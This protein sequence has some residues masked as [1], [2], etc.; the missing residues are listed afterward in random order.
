MNP[1]LINV[2]SRLKGIK[3]CGNGWKAHCPAHDD[4][5]QSLHVSK[6]EDGRVLL[7]CHAGCSVDEVC[8]AIGLTVRDLYP[9]PERKRKQAGPGEV[10]ATYD[11]KDVNGKQLFQVCRTANKHFFQRRPNGKGGWINGLG[12]VK[13][14]LYRLPELLQ[15]V[16]RGETVFIPE[17][18]K[19]VD[20]LAR[21]GL[22]ATTNP[23]GAGKWRPEYSDWLKG[24]KVIIIPDND[25]PGRKHA[26]QVAQSLYGKV[27]SVK[28]LELPGLPAKGDVSDWLAAG[29]TKEELLKLA[30]EAPEWEPQQAED[31][32]SE[33][34]KRESQA[35]ALIRIATTEAFL[36]HDDTKDGYAALPINGHRETW[37]LR[38]KF[39]R[40]WLVRRYYEQTEK[41]PNNEAIRQAL[42]VV[43]ARAVFDGPEIKLSLRVAEYED[44]LWYDLADE[45]W[46]AVKITPDGWDVVDNPPILF[47]R[48][49]NTAAQVLPQ[50]GGSLELLRK[51]INLQ[52]D[53][54]WTLLIA[55]IVQMFIPNIPHAIPVFYGDKG[56]AKTTAQRVIRK[57]IDPAHRDT[58]TLPSDKN[59]LA[60]MLMTNYAP[61]FDNL[62]GLSTWQ[63]DMLCQ[64]A[65]GGGIS[66]REL[67]TDTEEVIL[68]FLRCPMLNGINLV[69]SR[70]DLL[71]RSVLF[72]LERIDENERKTENEFWQEFERDRPYILGAIFDVLAK[73]LQIYPNVKLPALP[74]MADFAQW[75]YAIMEAVSGSGDEFLKAYRK[76]IADAV[77]EAVT[78]DV[79]GAAIVEFMDGK[80]E[81]QGTATELLEALNELPSVNEKDKAWPK[82]PNTLA[83]RLNRIKSALADYGIRLEEYR[84]PGFDRTRL[85]KISKNIVLTVPTVL[86]TPEAPKNKGFS[87]D[88]IKDD[89][90]DDRTITKK[91]SSFPEDLKNKVWDD[92]DDK[93]DIFPTSPKSDKPD[94]EVWEI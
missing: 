71:D 56:A 22:V 21:L 54:A 53:E 52:D 39:F 86:K 6:G 27:A 2:L 75:G 80:D 33:D 55:A 57:L 74:R 29:G 16:Q 92:K 4:Q 66:K 78:N 82:R 72:K 81:W 7:Y 48:F 79:V 47:R 50:R 23:M 70:D 30:A 83:R 18:E 91:I 94:W 64:A 35:D 1:A 3:P 8:A 58:M 37:P 61:C 89:I 40:Q 5:R 62:D 25:Q 60:L 85:L 88:D 41:S 26:Q 49:K 69:A 31:E 90:E 84:E 32:Q 67:Y 12:D 44:A 51:Y 11:Y 63:S 20:N 46:R 28:V 36:F 65:T 68:S 24:A 59:E 45:V 9:E 93:D 13:P 34:N 38:G 73:A 76:N 19:D 42:N 77:E 15:A 43:E 17:G 14:V 10:T 87:E